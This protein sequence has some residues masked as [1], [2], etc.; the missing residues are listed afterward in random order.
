MV[1]CGMC[2]RCESTVHSLMYFSWLSMQRKNRGKQSST[3]RHI[4]L[5]RIYE[6]YW[7]FLS[8]LSNFTRVIPP[9]T[10]KN[11]TGSKKV[12]LGTVLLQRSVVFLSCRMNHLFI[13]AS[14]NWKCSENE[15]LAD[16]FFGLQSF[17]FNAFGRNSSFQQLTETH[18]ETKSKKSERLYTFYFKRNDFAI[19]GIK[20][21]LISRSL[22]TPS[23]FLMTCFSL[24][25]RADSCTFTKHE[26]LY[27]KSAK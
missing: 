22:H 23:Q 7:S 1:N 15:L 18:S 19:L 26:G 9:R 10:K 14:W 20:F 2:P 3:W 4:C 13:A 12:P 11:F 21:L 27:V 25:V 8:T 5:P 6:G 24:E 17:I 16:V